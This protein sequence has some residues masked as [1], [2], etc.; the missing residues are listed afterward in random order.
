MLIKLLLLLKKP[1]II[2]QR[3]R[4]LCRPQ[5]GRLIRPKSTLKRR[6]KSRLKNRRMQWYLKLQ[7]TL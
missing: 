3:Q 5:Q 6:L 1:R 2:Q 7:K 4:G